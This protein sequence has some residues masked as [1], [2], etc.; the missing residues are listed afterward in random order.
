MEKKDWVIRC[1]CDTEAYM[2]RI[3]PEQ[4]GHTPIYVYGTKDRYKAMRFTETEAKELA[5][6]RQ[7][8]AIKLKSE[9]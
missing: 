9:G 3:I 8:E 1:G 5:K 7:A 6:K 4:L 2:T